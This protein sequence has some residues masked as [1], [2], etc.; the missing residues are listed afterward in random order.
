MLHLPQSPIHPLNEKSNS[1]LVRP[2]EDWPA[3]YFRRVQNILT[4]Q[5]QHRWNVVRLWYADGFHNAI[6]GI[7]VAGVRA[8]PD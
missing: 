5:P 4:E 2:W 1:L 8:I 6:K 3:T 7:L